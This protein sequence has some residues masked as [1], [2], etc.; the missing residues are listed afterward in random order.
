M[1]TLPSMVKD[2]WQAGQNRVFAILVWQNRFV[3]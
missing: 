1:S 2:P 3:W